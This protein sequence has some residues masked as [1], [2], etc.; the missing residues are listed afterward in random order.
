MSE[1]SFVLR[2]AID[3]CCIIAK[4]LIDHIPKIVIDAI[5]AY[6][7]HYI[8]PQNIVFTTL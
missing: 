8:F 7:L 1:N 3:I 5:L 2:M 4:Y 6:S